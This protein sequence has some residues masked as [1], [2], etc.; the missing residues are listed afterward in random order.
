MH[1]CVEQQIAM[2][3]HTIRHNVKNRLV[4]TNFSRSSETVSRYF[5]KVLHT[6]LVLEGNKTST[7]FKK[8]HLNGCAKALNNYFKI[9]KTIDQISNHLKTLK[10]K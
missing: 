9:N 7:G 6:N 8:V 1:M 2:F 5:N 10:K 3:L 4:R